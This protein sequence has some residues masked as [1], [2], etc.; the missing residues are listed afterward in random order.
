[1]LDERIFYLLFA[2]VCA[3]LIAS[4]YSFEL[5]ALFLVAQF[6][7]RNALLHQNKTHNAFS[8]IFDQIIDPAG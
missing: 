2:L 8:F 5:K 1:M 7:D 6:R 4:R 3:D